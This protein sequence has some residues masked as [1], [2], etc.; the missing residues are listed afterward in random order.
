M[1][2]TDTLVSLENVS[3]VFCRDLK[4]S[5]WYGA[6]DI[7]N[8]LINSKKRKSK[9]KAIDLGPNS[10]EDRPLR[11]G[12]FW[13]N[14]DIT[15]SLKRGECLGLIGRNG[16]GKT[17]LLKM[18]NGIIKPDT[19][20]ISLRGRLGSLIALG[21]GFN[22]ILTGRENIVANAMVLGLSPQQIRD[23]IDEIIDFADLREFIDSPVR[24]YSS[25]MQVRLGFSVATVIDPDILILD[26]VLAVGDASFRHKCYNRINK[27]VKQSAVILVSHSMDYIGQLATSVGLLNR[28]Q[29]TIY[30]DVHEGI[31][32][33]NDMVTD[34]E[35]TMEA[36]GG[37]VIAH[38]PPVNS[39]EVIIP[40]S[41]EYGEELEI[42]IRLVLDDAIDDANI[43]F[44]LVNR[45]E[46]NV[47][48]FHTGNNRDRVLLKSGQQEICIKV[49]NLWL[50]QGEY[51][52]SLNMSRKGSIEHFV[53]Q[54]RA[55]TI[56]VNRM[57]RPIGDIPYL[58]DA[59]DFIIRTI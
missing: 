16:A 12:E 53:W 51:K 1:N 7:F 11:K 44:I 30:K 33:Y 49:R 21:A 25:G 5:M 13:A 20:N 18:L 15:F 58:P 19:G 50:H 8:T 38:Y 32:A 17:T 3:K 45:N 39:V 6:K 35:S 54:M 4:Q 2:S 48:C 43:S 24:N 56:T 26:E 37:K 27:L 52:W 28:G 42:K 57:G 22:P 41:V 29:L 31:A 10:P 55:G 40:S 23:Q 14:K 34:S 47:M 9:N 46:Q 36:D 59:T